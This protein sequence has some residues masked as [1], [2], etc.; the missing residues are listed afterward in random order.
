MLIR[1]NYW[2]IIENMNKTVIQGNISGTIT[3]P[4]SKSQTIRALLIAA[5]AEGVSR[6]HNPLNSH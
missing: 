4:S 3:I 1:I 2:R 5:A 6:L